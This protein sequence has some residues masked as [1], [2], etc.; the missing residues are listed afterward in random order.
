[1]NSTTILCINKSCATRTYHIYLVGF[2]LCTHKN[3]CHT[4]QYSLSGGKMMLKL[5]KQISYTIFISYPLSCLP[6][7]SLLFITDVKFAPLEAV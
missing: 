6:F 1:M 3:T 2:F 4:A 7:P 5:K